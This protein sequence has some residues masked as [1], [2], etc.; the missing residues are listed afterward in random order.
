MTMSCAGM[1]E[2]LRRSAEV[3]IDK[4]GMDRLTAL[5]RLTRIAERSL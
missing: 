5:N 4:S 2:F 3:D 1:K